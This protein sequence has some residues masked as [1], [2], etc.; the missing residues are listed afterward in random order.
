MRRAV[1]SI[2]WIV[3]LDHF[4]GPWYDPQDFVNHF[5]RRIHAPFEHYDSKMKVVSVEPLTAC[6]RVHQEMAVGPV[7]RMA[8]IK[9]EWDV[10]LDMVP[11][12]WHESDD[13]LML[14]EKA[15]VEDM[16]PYQCRLLVSV[17]EKPQ[18]IPA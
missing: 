14:L 3:T 1:F 18:S 16:I 17:S 10:R 8:R 5:E 2:D 7:S 9:I 15:L 4:K 6:D 13:H 11:G 12:A